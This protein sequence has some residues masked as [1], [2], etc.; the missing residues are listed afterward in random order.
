[1]ALFTVHRQRTQS[2]VVSAATNEWRTYKYQLVFL[3]L[4]RWD[5]ET[6]T[7]SSVTKFMSIFA[8]DI[9]IIFGKK[10]KMQNNNLKFKHC[11]CAG[12]FF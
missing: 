8:S 4:H 6:E 10:Y 7:H 11:L 3:N 1:M 5:N 9:I 12:I 2:Q